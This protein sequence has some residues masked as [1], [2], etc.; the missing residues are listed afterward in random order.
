MEDKEATRRTQNTHALSVLFI[1]S[2]K[3]ILKINCGENRQRDSGERVFL[4][5]NTTPSL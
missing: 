5:Q 4:T 1:F 2:L 3:E